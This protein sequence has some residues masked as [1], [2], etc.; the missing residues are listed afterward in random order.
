MGCSVIF[1]WGREGF[2]AVNVGDA[3]ASGTFP[4][5]FNPQSCIRTFATGLHFRQQD[6]AEAVVGAVNWEQGLLARDKAKIHEN[7]LHVLFPSV[8]SVLRVDQCA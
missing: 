4:W 8:S 5:W 1:S 6:S 7:M 2:C 3:S